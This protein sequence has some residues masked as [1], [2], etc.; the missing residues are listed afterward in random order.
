M[1]WYVT[2]DNIYI[3]ISRIFDNEDDIFIVSRNGWKSSASEIIFKKAKSK[4]LHNI[5]YIWMNRKI[6]DDYW[7]SYLNDLFEIK[8]I[9]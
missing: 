6:I 2:F 8:L 9:I 1:I 7:L 3:P 5:N 4:I